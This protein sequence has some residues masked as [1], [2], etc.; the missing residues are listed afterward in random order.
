MKGH[1]QTL[2]ISAAMVVHNALRAPG[3]A[4]GVVDGDQRPL[5][6]GWVPVRLD[7]R[8]SGFVLGAHDDHWRAQITSQM[9]VS[10]VDQQ[11]LGAAVLQDV[12]QFGDRKTSIEGDE[13]RPGQGHTVVRLQQHTVVE[14]Q[15]GHPVSGLHA[16]S[17]QQ[18]RLAVDPIVEF[19]VGPLP[20]AIDD[21]PA[22]G[23]Q[24]GAAL[25]EPEGVNGSM[26][27]VVGSIIRLSLSGFKARVEPGSIAARMSVDGPAFQPGGQ[28]QPSR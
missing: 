24:H 21:C 12:L 6:V 14:G 15:H 27:A 9:G 2:Q 5:V 8:K 22:V 10:G 26:A 16:E 13:H 1:G 17:A 11:Y 19:S 28:A 25:E 7:G 4:A 20:I 23:K 18:A 3:S